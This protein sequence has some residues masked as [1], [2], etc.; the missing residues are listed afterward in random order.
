MASN[1][2]KKGNAATGASAA[3]DDAAAV[4][5]VASVAENAGATTV[6]SRGTVSETGEGGVPAVRGAKRRRVDP[7]AIMCPFEL[8]GVCNDDDCRCAFVLLCS[9]F[10]VTF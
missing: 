10:V 3:T 6:S 5:A 8:N 4:E 2:E 7:N 1:E 9:C